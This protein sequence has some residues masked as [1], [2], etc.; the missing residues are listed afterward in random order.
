VKR[1]E[2]YYIVYRFG[3]KQKWERIGLD[4][5]K[6]EEVLVE[7]MNLINKGA[8]REPKRISF[9]TFADKWVED[10]ASVTLPHSL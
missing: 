5:R 2:V 6:A 9:A 7:R 1:G 8:Y 10:Y 4:R 3:G